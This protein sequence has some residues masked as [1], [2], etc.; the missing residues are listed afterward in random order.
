MLDVASDWSSK[1]SLLEI[2]FKSFSLDL[3]LIFYRPSLSL[4]PYPH[5]S[6]LASPNPRPLFV[7]SPSL[8]ILSS[9][10]LPSSLSCCFLRHCLWSLFQ[11]RIIKT[12]GAPVSCGENRKIKQPGGVIYF[13]T[14]PLVNKAMQC[15][16]RQ[17]II[18]ISSLIQFK[19]CQFINRNQ[20]HLEF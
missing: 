9:F 16:K 6:G 18:H 12:P 1:F 19:R 7:S 4:L 20:T 8:L 17:Q 10:L 15:T 11:G 13:K 2:A 3:T 5:F 14:M